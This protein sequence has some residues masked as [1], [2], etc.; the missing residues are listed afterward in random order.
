MVLPKPEKVQ[1]SYIAEENNNTGKKKVRKKYLASP[2]LSDQKVLIGNEETLDTKWYFFSSSG[3]PGDIV[4][5]CEIYIQDQK[6]FQYLYSIK[7]IYSLE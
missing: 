5:S 6:V 1:F 7:N 4:G 3:Q 2:D